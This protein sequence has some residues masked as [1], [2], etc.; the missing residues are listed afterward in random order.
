MK[1]YSIII[2]GSGSSPSD[3]EQLTR[4]LIS[5]LCANGQNVFDAGLRVDGVLTTLTGQAADLEKTEAAH[6]SDP[7]QAPPAQVPAR[8]KKTAAKKDGPPAEPA[9][10][11]EPDPEG[12][13]GE[14]ATTAEPAAPPPAPA[15]APPAA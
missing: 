12:P 7:T 15:D 8:Q 6:L 13:T 11:R 2:N 4:D 9:T 10:T 3:P 5:H 1:K 14:A